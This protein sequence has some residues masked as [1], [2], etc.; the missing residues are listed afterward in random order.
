M[1]NFSINYKNIPPIGDVE[2]VKKIDN[3]NTEGDK[4]IPINPSALDSND[5]MNISREG[6]STR[7]VSVSIDFVSNDIH[8]SYKEPCDPRHNN[9]NPD[10]NNGGYPHNPIHQDPWNHN[11]MP[12]PNDYD[13]FNPIHQD[14]WNHNSGGG[15]PINSNIMRAEYNM[16]IREGD[17]NTLLRLA[18]IEKRHNV[19]SDVTA[20]DILGKAYNIGKQNSD[21]R[22]LF[23]I[24]IYEKD[25]NVLSNVTT[26][27]IMTSAYKSALSNRDVRTL[28]D[29]AQYERAFNVMSNVSYEQ[30]VQ[31][32]N[33]LQY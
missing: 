12:Y 3:E 1:E 13:D 24:A 20:E 16:A 32:I 9:Y 11:P 6:K 23:K 27:N 14:P 21:A 33:N 8:N 4:K 18:H 30:I 10:Y 15:Y 2:K 5:N 22:A 7:R 28:I 29:I 17:A 25:N 19:L 31:D 26:D